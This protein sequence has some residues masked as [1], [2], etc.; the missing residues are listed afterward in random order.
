YRLRPLRRLLRAGPEPLGRR[1]RQPAGDRGRRPRGGFWRRRRLSLRAAHRRRPSEGV[2]GA[3]PAHCQC[4]TA[5]ARGRCRPRQAR[6]RRRRLSATA[7]AREQGG[8]R[9]QTATL[10]GHAT[11]ERIAIGPRAFV[12]TGFA[13]SGSGEMLAGIAR[14]E[15]Q[16]PFRRMVTPGGFTMS[17]AMTNCGP[18]GWVSDEDGYRYSPVDP[19]TG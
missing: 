11:G 2:R 6:E 9:M 13:L 1:G 15:A 8:R 12:L 4:A 3:H 5:G 19:E 7:A 16:A 14:I 17:V 10:L 18:L